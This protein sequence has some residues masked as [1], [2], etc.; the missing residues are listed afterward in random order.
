MQYLDG[1]FDI[2]GN[3]ENKPLF[4]LDDAVDSR[5]TF[6]IAA[7]LLKKSGSG[8]VYPLALTSTSI[9]E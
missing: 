5:W 1:V 9:S 8:L 3:V 7:T 2:N 4:L 6:T